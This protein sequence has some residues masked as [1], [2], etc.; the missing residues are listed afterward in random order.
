MSF[1][2][3]HWAKSTIC[4]TWSKSSA[5]SPTPTPAPSFATQ[6][7]G[8]SN[9]ASKG[10]WV[11]EARP[12]LSPQHGEASVAC[13]LPRGGGGEGKRGLRGSKER[14]EGGHREG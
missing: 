12:P 13:H 9:P 10:V 14:R 6:G 1:G 11:E 2:H 5:A 7:H 4:S 8:G 3:L